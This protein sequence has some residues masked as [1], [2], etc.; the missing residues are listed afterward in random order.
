MLID[1]QANAELI[2]NQYDE[3]DDKQNEIEKLR[4]ECTVV[5]TEKIT[6]KRDLDRVDSLYIKL[7]KEFREQR[8]QFELL[9]DEISKINKANSEYR[10]LIQTNEEVLSNVHKEI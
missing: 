2:Q 9:V 10:R 8:V 3:L 5:M 7:Q 1:S 4:L 6:L